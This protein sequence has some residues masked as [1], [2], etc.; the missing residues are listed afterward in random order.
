MPTR[1]RMKW[2]AIMV[3]IKLV[4]VVVIKIVELGAL[5]IV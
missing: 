1:A 5:L 2:D 4:K 3:A